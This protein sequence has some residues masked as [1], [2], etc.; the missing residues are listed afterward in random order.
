MKRAWIPLTLESGIQVIPLPVIKFY[1]ED[2]HENI[3]AKPP[4]SPPLAY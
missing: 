2:E 1:W 4:I 3:L